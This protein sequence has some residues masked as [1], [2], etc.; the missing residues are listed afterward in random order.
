MLKFQKSEELEPLGSRTRPSDLSKS[1][2][3]KDQDEPTNKEKYRK[4]K[5][6]LQA[7]LNQKAHRGSK[8][9]MCNE[10]LEAATKDQRRRNHHEHCPEKQ[11]AFPST[12]EKE[13]IF[14]PDDTVIEFGIKHSFPSPS[15]PGAKT[16]TQCSFSSGKHLLK[17]RRPTPQTKPSLASARAPFSTKGSPL[18]RSAFF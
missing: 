14:H 11:A 4:S 3:S 15:K 10:N 5:E 13:N 8:G 16:D 12:E 7:S 17:T 2:H 6:G 9:R 1:L 18:K